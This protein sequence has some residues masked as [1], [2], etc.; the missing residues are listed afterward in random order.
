MTIDRLTR[1]DFTQLPAGALVIRLKEGDIPL[2]VTGVRD[3]PA[4]SPRNA[5]FA[6]ALAGPRDPLLPQGIYPM[7]HPEHG[8]LDLFVVPMARDQANSHYELVFN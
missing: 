3:L 8:Q 1:N 6:V 2:T 4:S 7:I 5:P